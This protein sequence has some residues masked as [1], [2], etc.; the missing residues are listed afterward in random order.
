MM[1]PSESEEKES[2]KPVQAYP[3]QPP[4]F[5][6]SVTPEIERQTAHFVSRSNRA[7]VSQEAHCVLT[8]YLSFWVAFELMTIA[9]LLAYLIVPSFAS[10]GSSSVS[11]SL[12]CQL[13]N[14]ATGG[15]QKRFSLQVYSGFSGNPNICTDRELC[16]PWYDTEAWKRFQQLATFASFSV[17][18]SQTSAT[19]SSVQAIVPCAL[20]FLLLATVLHVYLLTKPTGRAPSS[21]IWLYHIASWSILLSWILAL[22]GQSEVLYAAPFVPALWSSFFRQGY[23]LEDLI[24]AEP[25][26]RPTIEQQ[27]RGSACLIFLEYEG[28]TW[29]AVSTGLLFFLVWFTIIAGCCLGPLLVT[30]GYRDSS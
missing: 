19:L 23:T 6:W 27:Q 5:G 13:T 15:I 12:G 28:G 10:I 4:T 24:S 8:T 11:N 21:A 14:P 18:Y 7:E 9:F 20:F 2:E 30:A 25:P 22:V 29:L 16:I 3:S 26:G 17:D 1:N